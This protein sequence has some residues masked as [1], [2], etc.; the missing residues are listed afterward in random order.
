MTVATIGGPAGVRLVETAVHYPRGRAVRHQPIARL[1]S[2]NANRGHA[3]SSGDGRPPGGYRGGDEG[4]DRQA[5]DSS[6]PR[7]AYLVPPPRRLVYP[8]PSAMSHRE[9]LQFRDMVE[10]R[11]NR[12]HNTP[13]VSQRDRSDDQIR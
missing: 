3:R 6:W 5:R 10:V 7:L 1:V 13:F 12:P 4:E 11:I 8:S 9:S 2:K